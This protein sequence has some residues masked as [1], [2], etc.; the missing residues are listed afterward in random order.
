[1]NQGGGWMNGGAGGE[2]WLWTAIGVLVVV[3][4]VVVIAKLF[5]K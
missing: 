4:L 3:V 5:K 2:T 1:M